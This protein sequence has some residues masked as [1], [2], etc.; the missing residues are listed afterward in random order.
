M[1]SD[2]IFSG[3]RHRAAAPAVG[4]AFR[5]SRAALLPG[6]LRLRNQRT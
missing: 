2:D 4:R 1:A 3:D 5:G 6:L